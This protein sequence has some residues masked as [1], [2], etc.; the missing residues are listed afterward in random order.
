MFS[1]LITQP[2]L[3]VYYALQQVNPKQPG[4]WPKP[5]LSHHENDEL[6]RL[7]DGLDDVLQAFQKG[8]DQRD[9]LR[10]ISNVDGLTGIANRRQFDAVFAKEWTRAKANGQPLAIIFMDIDQF[11]PYNDHYGHIEGDDC[12]RQVAAALAN[13]MVRQSDFV[14]RYGGEEFVCVL[15]N[16]ALNEALNVAE[17]IQNTIAELKIPH[18][19]ADEQAFITLSMGVAARV[20]GP[21]DNTAEALLGEADEQLYRAKS[22]GRNRICSAES[23]DGHC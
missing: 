4:R 14:A 13:A 18:I 12:L 1:W 15:P 22:Q 9:Q 2:L 19:E 6:G 21:H 3:R 17:R 23:K 16:T 20:P 11:K 8:L 5:E 7:V 10:H